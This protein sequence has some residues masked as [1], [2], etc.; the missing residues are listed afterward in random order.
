MKKYDFAL[1]RG[2]DQ[3][4]ELCGEIFAKVLE[5]INE[6]YHSTSHQCIEIRRRSEERSGGR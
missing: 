3:L 2:T 1:H 5:V 6:L 4:I